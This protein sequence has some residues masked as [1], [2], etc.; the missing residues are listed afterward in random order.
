MRRCL[1][2]CVGDA[3]SSQTAIDKGCVCARFCCAVLMHHFHSRS[4]CVGVY[5]APPFNHSVVVRSSLAP[6]DC[7]KR[8]D[9]RTMDA[10]PSII[11]NNMGA[12]G[13]MKI[14]SAITIVL[15]VPCALMACRPGLVRL[16]CT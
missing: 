4:N 3:A 16:Y 8:G 14:V 2:C 1:G 5:H 10:E 11:C 12:H 9:V 6:F 7:T 13:R 15:C